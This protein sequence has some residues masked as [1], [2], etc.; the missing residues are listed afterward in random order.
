M[1]MTKKQDVLLT[2]GLMLWL[3]AMVACSER[4]LE[5]KEENSSLQELPPV[6]VGVEVLD[7]A[8][9]HMEIIS[10]GK[11]ESAQKAEMRFRINER[12]SKVYVKNGQSVRKGAILARL[13]D[14][15]LRNKL[16]LSKLALENARV[17]L[18]DILIEQG[19]ELQDS[20]S[21]PEQ[22]WTLAKI[23]SGYERAKTDMELAQFNLEQTALYASTSGIIADLAV[24]ENGYPSTQ[25][26]FCRIININQMEMSFPIMEP[27]MGLV[28]AGQ[29]VKI[30]PY[31]QEEPVAGSI[32]SV[33]PVVDE[34]GLIQVVARIS[35]ATAGQTLFE[36]MNARVLVNKKI[37]KMLAVPKTA[38]TLRSGR[39]VVFVYNVG[40]AKWIYVESGLENST[41]VVIKGGLSAGDSVIVEGNL[42]LANDSRVTLKAD[43]R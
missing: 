15:E 23:K 13:D 41:H 12:I 18:M 26:P 39:Q 6:S 42:H 17:S 22:K 1:K 32:V 2:I 27:E 7:S 36:G 30:I 25:E 8:D 16:I 34:S 19:Y 20:A 33:N 5:D 40:I 37:G 29:R 31:Y 28:N 3:A 11:L 9:F 24:K 4:E 14:F 10:N 21:I 38:V 43:N 35:G